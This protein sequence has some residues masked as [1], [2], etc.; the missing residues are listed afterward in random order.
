MEKF[1]QDKHVIATFIDVKKPFNNVWHNGIQV[2]NLPDD[3]G[4]LAMSKNIDLAA[5]YLQTD[6][7]KLARWCAKW[8]IMLNPEKER[9]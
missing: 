8:R 2:Q 1:N 6:L 4:Q 3:A 5:E 7:D 9:S